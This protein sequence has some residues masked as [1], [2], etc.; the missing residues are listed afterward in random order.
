MSLISLQR[1]AQATGNADLKRYCDVIAAAPLSEHSRLLAAVCLLVPQVAH[2]VG[3]YRG[4]L[5]PAYPDYGRCATTARIALGESPSQVTGLPRRLAHEYLSSASFSTTPTRW[6]LREVYGVDHA[7]EV[8]RDVRVAL[9]L[10]DRWRDPEQRESLLAHRR[11]MVA[12]VPVE[13][14]LIDRVDELRVSDL[15]PSVR[16]TYERAGKRL[17][18]QIQRTLSRE[19]RPLRGEPSW[20]RPARCA[21]LLMTGPALVA[22]GKQMRHCVAGYAPYVRD[23][24]SVIVAMSV[25]GERST[26]ELDP[27]TLDV[28][29]HLGPQNTPP[30]HLCERALRVLLSRWRAS[31]QG[32]S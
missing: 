25:R 17:E 1:V 31:A 7:C 32:A 23:G 13:G 3:E 4:P 2:L 26:V 22:E 18:R 16:D 28:R 11:A 6:L 14:R 8:V 27:R 15:R 12:G 29:Q 9:W 21:Q 10:C 30:H 19:T 20:W 5:A 24:R